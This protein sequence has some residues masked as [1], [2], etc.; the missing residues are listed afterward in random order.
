MSGIGFTVREPIDCLLSCPDDA[1][2]HQSDC[3]LTRQLVIW[4]KVDA[5][6]L[7]GYGGPFVRPTRSIERAVMSPD[8]IGDTVLVEL[9]ERYGIPMT[10]FEAVT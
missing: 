8:V 5:A 7:R 6:L 2:V 10:Y 1:F 3:P 9:H 4:D